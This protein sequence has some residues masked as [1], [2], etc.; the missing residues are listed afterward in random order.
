MPFFLCF[1]LIEEG[2]PRPLKMMARG[3]R[4]PHSVCILANEYRIEWFNISTPD[5]H[6]YAKI[7]WWR[8]AMKFTTP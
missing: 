7:T 8:A 2:L 3:S 4:D 1:A 6:F 5:N